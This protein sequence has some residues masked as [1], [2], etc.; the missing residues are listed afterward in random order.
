M[1]IDKFEIPKLSREGRR[2]L[3]TSNKSLARIATV[4]KKGVPHVVPVWFLFKNGLICI[5]TPLRTLKA[6]NAIVRPEVSVVIDQYERKLNAKGMLF[7]G[8][9]KVLTGR[10][11]SKLNFLVHKKYMGS[12]KLEESKWQEFMAEDDGT[13]VV[14]SSRTTSW[15]FSNLDL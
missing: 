15:D 10:E 11:S 8:K 5:P 2:I 6:K 13:I 14:R 4:N 12:K 7:E 1:S 9:A 3:L